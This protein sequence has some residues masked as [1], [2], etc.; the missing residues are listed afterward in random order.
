MICPQCGATSHVLSTRE[1]PNLTTVRRRQCDAIPTH[2]FNSIEIHASVYCSAKQR[3]S[4]FAQT[5][6]Q[7]IAMVQ[8]DRKIA[9]ELH[10]GWHVLAAR[11]GLTKTAVYLAAKRGRSLP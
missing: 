4:V 5:T 7:R 10:Q 3:A 9:A 1:G 8:R 6:R 2:R 11:Y